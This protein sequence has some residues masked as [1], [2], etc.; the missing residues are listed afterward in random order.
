MRDGRELDL[1]ASYSEVEAK[2]NE[3]SRR[4]F[5]R[6]IDGRRGSRWDEERKRDGDVTDV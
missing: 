4:S 1:Y 6:E 2:C 5:T 3:E